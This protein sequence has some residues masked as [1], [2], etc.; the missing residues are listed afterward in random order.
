M[1]GRNNQLGAQRE[2]GLEKGRLLQNLEMLAG[3]TKNL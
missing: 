2:K 3:I 1:T